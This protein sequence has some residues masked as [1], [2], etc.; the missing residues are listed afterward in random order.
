MFEVVDEWPV[1]LS[2]I[3]TYSAVFSC[4][5][6]ALE[7]SLDSLHSVDAVG[8]ELFAWSGL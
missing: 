3:G 1:V 5:V 6:L 8:V 4:S 7:W 2:V